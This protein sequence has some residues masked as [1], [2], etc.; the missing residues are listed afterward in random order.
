MLVGVPGGRSVGLL[1]RAV[2]GRHS[3]SG[4]AASMPKAKTAPCTF[5]AICQREDPRTELLYEDANFVAFRDIRPAAQHHYL[6]CPKRH[7]D[8]AR[9]LVADDAE[10][11]ERLMVIGKEVLGRQGVLQLDSPDCRM[12]FHWPP[13]NGIRHLHLHV[14]YPASEMSFISRTIFRPNTWWF[15]TPEWVV[16]RLEKMSRDEM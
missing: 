7:V 14:L 8:S 1:L 15:V 9:S 2:G 13:F 16:K 4:A 12:G 3:V 6:I 11:V 5:C 10:L